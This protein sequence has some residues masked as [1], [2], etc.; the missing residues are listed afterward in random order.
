MRKSQVGLSD[1]L[2]LRFAFL[3]PVPDLNLEELFRVVFS[4]QPGLA[5]FELFPVGVQIVHYYLCASG[6]H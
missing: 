4:D 2:M 3:F 1:E 6:L 5:D